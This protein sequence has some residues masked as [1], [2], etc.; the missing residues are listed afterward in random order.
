[1]DR[2]LLPLILAVAASCGGRREAPATAADGGSPP[3]VVA[4]PH[5]ASEPDAAPEETQETAQPLPVLSGAAAEEI[6]AE[7]V[8]PRETPPA[9][10]DEPELRISPL[11]VGKLLLGMS[12]REVRGEL[13]KR[14]TIAKVRTPPGEVSVE[15]GELHAANGLGI[16]SLRL[17]GGRLTEIAVVARDVRA[18]TD[19][20]IMV[21]S[22]F[23]EALLAYGDAR[24]VPRG[25]V[26]EDLPGVIL[27]PEASAPAGATPDPKARIVAIVVVGPESD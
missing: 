8:T 1:M 14:G 24:R 5:P 20:D 18:K 7:S 23:D 25:Y 27:V 17:Y 4:V 22:T 26:L 21:G 13:G 15:L 11:G 10:P 12:R 9:K 2:R 16:L 6:I 19:R 3:P